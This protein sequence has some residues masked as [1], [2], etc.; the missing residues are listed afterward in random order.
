MQD[1][2]EMFCAAI[3]DG[4]KCESNADVKKRCPKTCK[5]CEA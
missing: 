1:A 2:D 3:A 4:E 5:I